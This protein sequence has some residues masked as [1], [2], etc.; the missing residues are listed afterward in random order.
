MYAVRVN[1][2][3]RSKIGNEVILHNYLVEFSLITIK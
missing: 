2:R 3:L 1:V